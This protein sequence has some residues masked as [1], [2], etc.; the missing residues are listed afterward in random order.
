MS[1]HKCKIQCDAMTWEKKA[2]KKAQKIPTDDDQKSFHSSPDKKFTQG[3][4]CF[5]STVYIEA[6]SLRLAV[7]SCR[8]DNLENLKI[9]SFIH[10]LKGEGGAMV[11]VLGRLGQKNNFSN[12]FWTPPYQWFLNRFGNTFETFQELH[13]FGP[14]LFRPRKFIFHLHLMEEQTEGS[15]GA[16]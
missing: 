12:F 3:L 7:E 4:A 15:T 8:C 9:L 1:S 10:L 14:L 2:Q 5:S 16:R 6:I 13:G 11:G